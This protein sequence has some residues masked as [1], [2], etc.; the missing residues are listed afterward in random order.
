MSRTTDGDRKIRDAFLQK[1]GAAAREAQLALVQA[2]TGDVAIRIAGA[3]GTVTGW[4]RSASMPDYDHIP[5]L[6]PE[7]VK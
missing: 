5:P 4:C 7:D 1:V 2:G 3:H 6:K